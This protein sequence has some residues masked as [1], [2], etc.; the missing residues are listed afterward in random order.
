MPD[1][2]FYER[3]AATTVGELADLTGARL[4][5]LT[6]AGHPVVGVGSLAAAATGDVAFCVDRRHA[7]ALGSTAASACFLP[8]AVAGA[9][10]PSCAPL[11]TA[12]PQAAYALAVDRLY[13]PRTPRQGAPLIDPSAR[14]DE[15]V[16]IGPGAVVGADAE[17]GAGTRVGPGA[18]VGPGV[19][20]GRQCIIGPRT[21]V[22]YALLG[23]RVRV[24]AGAIIGEPGFGAAGGPRGV[25]DIPQLGRVI[26]G[27]E[28]TVGANS[29]IDRGAF[30]DT[31]IGENTKIDNLVQIAHNVVIGR[32]CLL[33]AYTGISGSTVVGDGCV[34]GGRAGV[35]D[36]VTIGS[37]ARVAA[38]S[39]VMK[40]IP[41]GE[42]WG[43]SPAR[44]VVRWM[45][46]TAWLARMAKRRAGNEGRP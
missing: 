15:D 21:V 8:D 29:C 31:V 2:R 9:A 24:H 6:R 1:P 39:G 11:I 7:A 10:P 34:F 26:I 37:G 13:R 5:D 30:D 25:I 12:T 46:E 19:Q 33:A 23:D 35:S 32:N 27:D 3:L 16:E 28:V 18:Y 22:V 38:A 41:A 14:I 17:I 42:S 40:D 45:R 4:T 20:I 44:P 36:H 43:G